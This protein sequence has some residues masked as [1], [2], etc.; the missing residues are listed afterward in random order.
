MM[1]ILTFY[2]GMNKWERLIGSGSVILLI[3]KSL[4]VK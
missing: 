3:I 4:Y 2:A 1:N